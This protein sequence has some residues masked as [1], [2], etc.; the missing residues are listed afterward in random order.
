MAFVLVISH[1]FVSH[2]EHIRV[3]PAKRPAEELLAYLYVDMVDKAW[4]V[5]EKVPRIEIAPAVGDL[6]HIPAAESLYQVASRGHR[7]KYASAAL[8]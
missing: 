2:L 5:V 3:V 6:P 7:V 4:P 8:V 1:A